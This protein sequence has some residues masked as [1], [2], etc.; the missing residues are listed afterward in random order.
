MAKIGGIGRVGRRRQGPEGQ[1]QHFN[2]FLGCAAEG[3]KNRNNRKAAMGPKPGKGFSRITYKVCVCAIIG[4]M[5][6]IRGQRRGPRGRPQPWEFKL[7]GAKTNEREES[8]GVAA[9]PL[10]LA[11]IERKKEERRKKVQL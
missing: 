9:S 1:P 4:V 10:A 5:R 3:R 2:V 8:E 6:I 7:F 11:L